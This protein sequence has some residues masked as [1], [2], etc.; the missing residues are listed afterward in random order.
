MEQH[1]EHTYPNILKYMIPAEVQVRPHLP[2]S[3]ESILLS[4]D[5]V[6]NCHMAVKTEFCYNY[7][8]PSINYT[9]N[10]IQ[11]NSHTLS[12]L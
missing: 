9:M 3:T 11:S 10:F 1:L 8:Y 7:F 5:S 12:S 2:A 4:L 6:I